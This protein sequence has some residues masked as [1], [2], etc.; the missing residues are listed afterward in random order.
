MDTQKVKLLNN[1]Q[2]YQL[3]QNRS[4]D[5]YTLDRVHQEFRLRNISP[6]ER[7][8]LERRYKETFAQSNARLDTKSWDPLYTAFAWKKHFKQ[9]AL[10]RSFN[11]E[12]EARVYQ[13]R[14]YL[15]M[16]IYMLLLVVIILV[17]RT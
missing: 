12:T 14:F 11:R 7:K 4:I 13:L 1:Y 9:I 8:E 3:S 6:L 5:A 17:L 16:G 10:L 2:L 15:G